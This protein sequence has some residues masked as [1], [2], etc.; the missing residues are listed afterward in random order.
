MVSV[1]TSHPETGEV[2]KEGH[3]G[4]FLWRI[5]SLGSS[6]LVWKGRPHIDGVIH[7]LGC[8][9]IS[10]VAIFNAIMGKFA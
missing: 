9:F 10:M 7:M 3:F 8:F 4:I 5:A 2:G 6:R 1:Q